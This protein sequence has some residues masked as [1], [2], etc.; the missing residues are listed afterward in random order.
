MK[1]KV[2]V[3]APALSAS[4]YGEHARFVLRAL[5]K[6]EDIFDIY[7]HNLNW[8]KVSWLFDNSEERQW[9]DDLIKKTAEHI[10]QNRENLFFDYSLQVT[11]PNEFEKIAAVNIG[12]TAGIET[13]KVAPQWLQKANE[14]DKLIV[15]S[16][17]AKSGFENTKYPLMNEQQEH[18]ADLTCNVPIEVVGYPVKKIK[19]AKID[20]ELETDFNFLAVALWGQRKN[21]EKTILNFVE[22]F[23]DE[24]N[25]GLVVKTAIRGGSTY[26]LLGTEQL[27]QR[28]LSQHPDRKCKVY[29]LHGRLSEEEMT[30][31]YNHDKIKCMVS[32]AH[33]EGFGLPLF[34]AA[35]NGLPIVATDWSGQ[36]DFLYAPQKDK[37]GKEKRKGLFGKVSYDLH[38]VQPES[39][40][41]GVIVP[42]SMWAYP[43]D[44]SA[45]TKM[46]E[47][48]KDYQL[49]LNKAKKLKKFVEEEFEADKMLDEMASCMELNSTASGDEDVVIL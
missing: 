15:V 10:N 44:R 5:R 9:I 27:L 7:L 38:K 1:K 35:Y 36:T 3:K 13:H 8:G 33:G 41:E 31:L 25:V 45:K 6:K 30:A 19:A 21:V 24:E 43:S 11:I 48:F 18:V 14:M 20:F 2:I 42:D 29:L 47:V 39:V 12:V 17:H 22:E 40:W 26:D 37:K 23:K 28:I 46:R 32:L 4:G 16:N 34:E 49:A